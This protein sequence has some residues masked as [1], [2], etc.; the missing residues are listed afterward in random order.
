MTTVVRDANEADVPAIRDLFNVLI[1]TTTVAWRD[2]P[3]SLADQEVWFGERQAAGDPVLVA[4]D[5]GEV[6]GY[7]CWSGFRG[8]HRFPGYRHTVE[9]SIH[10]RGDRQGEGIGR[11]LLAALVARAR[12]ASVHVLVAGIDADNEGSLAFHR[13]MGFSEVARMPE[14]GRKFDRWL[15]LVLLQM[16]VE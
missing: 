10:V 14:T 13:A 9:H 12:N 8:G 2:E 16:I 4:D 5:D 15:D 6:V 1:P 3:S 11:I 7:C